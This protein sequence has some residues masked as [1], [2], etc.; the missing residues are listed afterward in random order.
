MKKYTFLF[1]ISLLT[2]ALKG[3]SPITYEEGKVSFISSRNVY[4]KFAST[5][6]IQP[7]D[8]LFTR[9]EEV[10]IPALVVSNKSSS[11]TVCV[12]IGNTKVAVEA[13]VFAKFIAPPQVPISPPDTTITPPPV[14][15]TTVDTVADDASSSPYKEKIRGR[16]SIATYNTLSNTRNN[17]RMR[18]AFLFRGHHLNDSK[19][20]IDSYITFRHTSGEWNKVQ[21]SIGNALKIFSLSA[22]YEFNESSKL[23]FG[24]KINPSIL[25]RRGY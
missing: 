13:I 14:T 20:S 18:Y 19:L 2:I 17:M 6:N 7:G 4:V 1:C 24:R 21:E 10:F 9:L 16:I 25:K 15:R 12:P 8:T 22:S 5:Q 11:S 3:Q 23:T